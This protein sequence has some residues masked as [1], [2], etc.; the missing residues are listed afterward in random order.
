MFDKFSRL[1][2]IRIQ[3]KPRSWDIMGFVFRSDHG[4]FHSLSG[5]QCKYGYGMIGEM[6]MTRAA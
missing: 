1:P 4:K 6:G 2:L 3:G 5:D